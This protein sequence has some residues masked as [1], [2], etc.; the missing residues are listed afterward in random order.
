MGT[1][2]EKVIKIR[3]IFPDDYNP[4]I[5]TGALGGPMP[6]GCHIAVSFYMERG[7][8]PYSQSFQL[9]KEGK[10]EDEVAA[11]P[12]DCHRTMIRFVNSGIVVTPEVALTVAK[13]LEEQ[14][15]KLPGR[16]PSEENA[17]KTK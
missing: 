7:S 14:V 17:S 6:D 15:A 3:Y 11:D 16:M 2:E 10:L 8:L 12:E 13:W 1:E 4:T 9:S 5:A